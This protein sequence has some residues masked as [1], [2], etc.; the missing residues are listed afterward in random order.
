MKQVVFFV[1]LEHWKR[2]CK[3]MYIVRK[4]QARTLSNRRRHMNA[5]V[6]RV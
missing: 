6:E 3:R 5:V 2:V 4:W 1:Y